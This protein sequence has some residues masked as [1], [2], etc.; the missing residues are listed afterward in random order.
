MCSCVCACVCV[1]LS[2]FVCVCVCV[3]VCVSVC[4]FSHCIIVYFNSVRD[5][6]MEANNQPHKKKKH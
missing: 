5:V 2:L 6:S 4:L 1:S 3:C